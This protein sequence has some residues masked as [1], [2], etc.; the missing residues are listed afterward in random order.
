MSL[1]KGTFSKT[2]AI[3]ERPLRFSVCDNTEVS[4]SRK[5]EVNF[6]FYRQVNV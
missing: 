5:T 6:W 2:A 3:F 4:K 1:L